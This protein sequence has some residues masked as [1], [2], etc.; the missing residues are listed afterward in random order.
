MNETRK[1]ISNLYGQSEI[2]SFYRFIYENGLR[3]EACM[4]LKLIK[5]RLNLKTGKSS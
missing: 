3:V 2:E 4:A 1:P 5:S